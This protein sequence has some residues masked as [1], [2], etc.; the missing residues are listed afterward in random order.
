MA[1]F[2][3]ADVRGEALNV[4]GIAVKIAVILVNE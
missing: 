1:L 3:F 2:L 4:V